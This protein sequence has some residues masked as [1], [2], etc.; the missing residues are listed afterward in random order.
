RIRRQVEKERFE[1]ITDSRTL[2]ATDQLR[3]LNLIYDDPYVPWIN[4][5]II[6]DGPDTAYIAINNINK[7][8]CWHEIR[9]NE[10]RVFDQSSAEERIAQFYYRCDEG[11]TATV[12][13]EALF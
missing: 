1:G 4:A 9:A 8:N 3:V 7:P 12:R 10:T 5:F 6:N 11:E 2:E 13:V